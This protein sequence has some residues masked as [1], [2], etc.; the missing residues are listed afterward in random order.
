[1]YLHF[2]TKYHPMKKLLPLIILLLTIPAAAQ[3]VKDLEAQRKKT[4]QQLEL[5]GKLLNETK[6]NEKSTINKLNI[7]NRNI[8]TRRRLISNINTEIGT[9]DQEMNSLN[10]QKT[11]LEA[12][13]EMQK[14][15]YAELVQETHYTRGTHNALLFILS[16]D[17]FDKMFRRLRYLQ[18]FTE[19][20]KN[21]VKEIEALQLN[22]ETKNEELSNNKRNKQQVLSVREREQANLTR[23]QRQER[24]MLGELQKKEKQLLAQQKKQQA[25]AAKLNGVIERMIAEEIQKSQAKTGGTSKAKDTQQQTILTGNFEKHKGQLPWPVKSGFVSGKYGIQ[26]HAVLKN[27]TINNKG[28]YIQTAANADAYAIFEGEVTQCFSVQGG[29]SAVIVRHGNY[30]TVYA[31]LSKIYVSEGKNIKLGEA[32]GRIALDEKNDN[33]TELYFQVWKDKTILNPSYWIIKK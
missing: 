13:L 11:A 31:N 19:Y 29:A 23:N 18:E 15:A 24:I 10:V 32:V 6:K 17:S 27:I 21:Q 1:M 7:I 8:T 12:Q 5:T 16:A 25:E 4:L 26:A 2:M 30:R 9:L 33:K 3:T 20:R 22:I 28:I 14:T